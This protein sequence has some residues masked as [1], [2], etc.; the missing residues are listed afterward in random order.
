MLVLSLALTQT[1][2]KK[3]VILYFKGLRNTYMNAYTYHLPSHK[4]YFHTQIYEIYF[5]QKGLE[6]SSTT[7][8]FLFLLFFLLAFGADLFFGEKG[9]RGQYES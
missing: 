4:M 7:L 5:S 2:F 1:T 8:C 3:D 9:A 6:E